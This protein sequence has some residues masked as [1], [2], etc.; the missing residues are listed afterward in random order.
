MTAYPIELGGARWATDSA[1]LVREGEALP[2]QYTNTEG[3]TWPWLGTLPPTADARWALEALQIECKP[4]CKTEL[5]HERF[6]PLLRSSDHVDAVTVVI[7]GV[8]RRRVVRCWRGDQIV[9]LISPMNP[10]TGPGK[11]VDV[12]RAQEATP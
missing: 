1:C 2:Q 10:G 3:R 6:G 9:A 5:V 12:L 8:G 4:A 11:R 7:E